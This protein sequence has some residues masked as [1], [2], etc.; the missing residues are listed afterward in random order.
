MGGTDTLTSIEGVSG[1]QFN[2]YILGSAAANG[3]YGQSGNDTLIGGDGNDSLNGGVGAD[4]L[5]GGAG[6]D[7]L[8]GGTITDRYF[9]TDNNFTTYSGSTAAVNVNLGT[10]IASDGLGGTDA[11]V[12]INQ[13][14]GS[15]YADSLTGSTALVFEQFEGGLGNDTLDGGAITDTLMQYNNNR[16]SYSNAAGAVTVQLGCRHRQRCCRQRHPC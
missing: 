6:N 7:Y 5:V 11:L 10:G 12:N 2:D 4:T 13:V 9:G 15:S 1:T 14:Q 8:D 16:I 3:L